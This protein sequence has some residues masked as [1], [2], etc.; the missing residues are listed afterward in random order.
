MGRMF[1]VTDLSFYYFI[2]KKTAMKKFPFQKTHSQIMVFPKKPL[3]YHIR[4][5]SCCRCPMDPCRK[6]ELVRICQ[7]TH[8]FGIYPLYFPDTSDSQCS[9]CRC[10]CSRWNIRG[11]ICQ[12]CRPVD[13][14]RRCFRSR[15]GSTNIRRSSTFREIFVSV[16]TVPR[17]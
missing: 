13:R 5:C 16:E 6:S 4:I 3:S 7:Q 17:I 12:C 15:G 1:L 2:S 8:R 9:D 11:M 14:I 10:N